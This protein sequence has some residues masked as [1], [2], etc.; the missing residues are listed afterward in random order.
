MW[1]AASQ[2]ENAG[3]DGD[4]PVNLDG[5]VVGAGSP[6]LLSCWKSWKGRQP[7]GATHC[8][9]SPWSWDKSEGDQG[10][11]SQGESL[12]QREGQT[13]PISWLGNLGSNH[14]VA[15]MLFIQH[16]SGEHSGCFPP[17]SHTASSSAEAQGSLCHG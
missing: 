2:T 5:A 11:R 13:Q 17:D 3:P 8:S 10:P 7:R 16:P 4:A 6:G 9:G 12:G 1:V 14:S 15:K